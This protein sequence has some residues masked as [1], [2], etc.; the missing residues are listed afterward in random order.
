[1]GA[2]SSLR[3]GSVV[4]WPVPVCWASSGVRSPRPLWGPGRAVTAATGPAARAHRTA[5]PRR[6]RPAQPQPRR[7]R[8]RSQQPRPARPLTRQRP[9]RRHRLS[10]PN[11]RANSWCRLRMIRYSAATN[12]RGSSASRPDAPAGGSPSLTPRRRPRQPVPSRPRT[13]WGRKPVSSAQHVPGIVWTPGPRGARLAVR[14]ALL[15]SMSA[16]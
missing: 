14:S 8:R 13:L 7:P 4:A 6:D 5:D 11:C 10:D 9:R 12:R 1:M 16:K 3:I 15:L 2:P